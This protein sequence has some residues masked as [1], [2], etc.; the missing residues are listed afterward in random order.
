MSSTN[1][2][3]L[4]LAFLTTVLMLSGCNKPDD[5]ATTPAIAQTETVHSE[6]H[7]HGHHEHEHDHRH[8][9]AETY[10]CD[11]GK[12]IMIGVHEHEG[13]TE[14]YATIDDITY[15]LHQDTAAANQYISHEDGINNQ[16]MIISL[17]DN[18][19]VVTSLA[20]NSVLLT[21]QK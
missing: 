7:D 17:V 5:T 14:A 11:N 6:A 8:M 1:L 2:A 9:D 20:D 18:Q 15:D 4:S 21:C 3:H 16:G 12:M 13:E 10:T 19:A